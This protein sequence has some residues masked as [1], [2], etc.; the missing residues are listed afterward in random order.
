MIPINLD[1]PIFKIKY[2]I[3]TTMI[4][5][6]RLI[7]HNVECKIMSISTNF[8]FEFSNT[9]VINPKNRA[10]GIFNIKILSNK[11]FIRVFVWNTIEIFKFSNNFPNFYQSAL[12]ITENLKK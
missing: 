6:R 2:N 12:I 7:R 8:E 5:K 11:I 9:Y 10:K 1:D 3:N 4:A